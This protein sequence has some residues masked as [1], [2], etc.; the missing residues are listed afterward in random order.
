MFLSAEAGTEWVF[1]ERRYTSLAEACEHALEVGR[2]FAGHDRVQLVL[3]SSQGHQRGGAGIADEG[4][5]VRVTSVE[6]CP[7]E[8]IE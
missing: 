3:D 1:R 5:Y 7:S 8:F 6:P 4:G 2:Q